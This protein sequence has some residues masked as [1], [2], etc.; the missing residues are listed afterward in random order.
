[1][2]E[3]GRVVKFLTPRE[4]FL[5]GT[6]ALVI[7]SSLLLCFFFVPFFEKNAALSVEVRTAVYKLRKYKQLLK[8]KKQ[9]E[10]LAASC[11]PILRPAGH[12]A[13]AP[14]AVLFELENLAK[15]SGIRL[16]DIRPQGNKSGTLF[17]EILIDIRSE[18]ELQGYLKFM[19][20]LEHSLFLFELRKIQLKSKPN[21]SVIEAGFTISKLYTGK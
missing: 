14:E 3:G 1:M 20:S 15:D 11:S 7:V 18:G 17:S 2:R 9:I 13:E 21:S 12:D 16:I 19:Y 8:N 10:A 5:L 6:A 4:R